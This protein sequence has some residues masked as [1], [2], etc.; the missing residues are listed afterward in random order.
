MS[1]PASTK[2][3]ILG[4][5]LL[6]RDAGLGVYCEQLIE[7]ESVISDCQKSRL[8]LMVILNAHLASLGGIRGHDTPTQQGLLLKQLLDCCELYAVPLSAL[9]EGPLFIPF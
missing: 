3:T 6:C 4:V 7:L 1:R 8:V 5:Y 9:S 2:L